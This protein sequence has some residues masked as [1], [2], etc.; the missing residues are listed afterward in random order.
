ML[1]TTHRCNA[2]I[3]SF[4]LSITACTV[5]SPEEAPTGVTPFTLFAVPLMAT[6]KSDCVTSASRAPSSVAGTAPTLEEYARRIKVTVALPDG[7]SVTV[8]K[9]AQN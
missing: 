2:V 3:N 9:E 4:N 6:L 5:L 7:Q 8:S 1:A